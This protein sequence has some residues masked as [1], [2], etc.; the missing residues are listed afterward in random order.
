[1]IHVTDS[2]SIEENELQF[3]FSRASGPGGQNVNKVATAVQ[4]RFDAAGSAS[5]PADVKERLRQL[6]GARMTRDGTVVINA[7]RFRSQERNREDA[8][9]RLVELVRS[10]AKKPLRRIKSKPTRE[11]K[12]RRLEDKKHRSRTKR[13]RGPVTDRDG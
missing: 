5:L 2:I 11:S 6:A 13:R 3:V 4:L 10:A 7:R 9:G 1:M 12:E 8:V